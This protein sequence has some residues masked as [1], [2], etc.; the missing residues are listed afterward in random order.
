MACKSTTP[1]T[2]QDNGKQDT[3][4]EKA[5]HNAKWSSSDDTTLVNTFKTFVDGN[6]ADN[7]SFKP[8][9]FMVTAKVLEHSHQTSGGAVKT[10][11]N[12]SRHWAMLKANGLTV[13]QLVNLSGFG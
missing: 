4:N 3:P 12:C 8:A 7:G 11:K 5:P 1:T 6:S 10:M 2:S 9:A 13:Q